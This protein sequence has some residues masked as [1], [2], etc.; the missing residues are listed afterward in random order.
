MYK[1][2]LLLGIVAII[3]GAGA[4]IARKKENGRSFMAEKFGEGWEAGLVGIWLGWRLIALGIVLMAFPAEHLSIGRLFSAG[5]IMGTITIVAG[6]TFIVMRHNQNGIKWFENK[7]GSNW[8]SS[9]F[10][11]FMDWPMLIAG[12]TMWF[13][14]IWWKDIMRFAGI[15]IAFWVYMTFFAGKRASK[16]TGMPP[17]EG[18]NQQASN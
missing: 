2:M 13:P 8:Q 11:K 14:D 3:L 18:K 5:S 7:F 9:V 16:D 17:T 1:I 6:I 12:A 4:V 10:V 15:F